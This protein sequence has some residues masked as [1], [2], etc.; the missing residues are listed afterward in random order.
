MTC[1]SHINGTSL[2][3]EDSGEDDA[4]VTDR[5]T[6]G[7]IRHGNGL[8]FLSIKCVGGKQPFLSASQR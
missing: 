5:P 2:V 4:E 6:D 7:L 3:L 8:V 1:F